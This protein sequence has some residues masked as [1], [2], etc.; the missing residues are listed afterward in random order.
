MYW[1]IKAKVVTNVFIQLYTTLI[2]DACNYQ[3]KNQIIKSKAKESKS[4]IWKINNIFEE[5]FLGWPGSFWN[6]VTPQY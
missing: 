1:N 4:I 3:I 2:L 5:W 6:N